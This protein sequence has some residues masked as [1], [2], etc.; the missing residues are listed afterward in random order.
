MSNTSHIGPYI[1]H[2]GPDITAVA[3]A[4]QSPRLIVGIDRLTVGFRCLPPPAS[5]FWHT[6]TF[7]Q[8]KMTAG[9]QQVVIARGS[10]VITA[11][12]TFL[13]ST[14]F[15]GLL[16]TFNPS[17]L[18]DPDGT[19][20]APVGDVPQLLSDVIY[21]LLPPVVP[22][23]PIDRWDLYRLD[24][25]VDVESG[26]MTQQILRTAFDHAYRPRH[27]TYAYR[28]GPSA[29]GTVGRRS[30]TRPRLSIYDKAVE[31]KSGSPRVRFEIQCRREALR[32]LNLS[33][34]GDLD[35]VSARR[36]FI[37]EL[38]EVVHGLGATGMPVAF[39]QLASTDKKTVL[40]LVG[41]ETLRARGVEPEVS[42]SASRRYRNL[43]K[44]YA[45]TVMGGLS[46]NP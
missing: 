10:R 17:R 14:T 21:P 31:A 11:R 36:V 5:A 39:H 25:A 38:A 16:V 12:M 2:M 41:I 30:V 35:I 20:L 33:T 19:G 42:P 4:L 32:T 22:V 9:Q 7:Q 34:M 40:E 18:I 46:V 3:A 6:R 24:L 27:H 43:R 15:R 1:F 23:P 29:L 44:R 8:G 13:D 37:G 28:N 45:G 26:G